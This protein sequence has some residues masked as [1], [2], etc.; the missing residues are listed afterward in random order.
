[1]DQFSLPSGPRAVEG[2]GDKKRE[3]HPAV[4]C[5]KSGGDRCRQGFQAPRATRAGNLQGKHGV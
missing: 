1:M 3:S 5:G 2:R 4:L